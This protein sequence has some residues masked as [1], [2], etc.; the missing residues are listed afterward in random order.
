MQAKK[1]FSCSL[2]ISFTEHHSSAH[3]IFTETGQTINNEEI[4]HKDLDEHVV[5][6]RPIAFVNSSGSTWANETMRL[7][8][9]LPYA[10]EVKGSRQIG[11]QTSDFI[12]ALY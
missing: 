5:F 4:L 9:T 2:N 7:R 11:D 3:R 12:T 1:R 8:H 10:F 6:L